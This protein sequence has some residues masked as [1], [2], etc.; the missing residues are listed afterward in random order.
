MTDLHDLK[1][2]GDELVPIF[3]KIFNLS[4]L[5]TE[6]PGDPAAEAAINRLEKVVAEASQMTTGDLLE[7]AEAIVAAK[8]ALT[9]IIVQAGSEPATIPATKLRIVEDQHTALGA[10]FGRLLELTAFAAIP[11]LLSRD[12]IKTINRDLKN[13]TREI[14]QRQRAKQYLDLFVDIALTGGRIAARL[15]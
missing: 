8:E 5:D 14:K 10:S 3:K 13:T 6:I 11:S 4:D 1:A 15:G 12:E 9:E 2:L 7:R